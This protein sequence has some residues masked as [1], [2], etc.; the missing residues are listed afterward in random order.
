MTSDY[1]TPAA[2]PANSRLATAKIARDYG[3]AP[4]L[5]RE[6]IDEIVDMLVKEA[7]QI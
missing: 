7:A 1:P 6:A 2:R 4:R 3:I 5:W